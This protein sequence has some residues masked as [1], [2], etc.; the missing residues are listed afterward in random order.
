MLLCAADV[1]CAAR[2][3]GALKGNAIHPN[4]SSFFWISR[5]ALGE[6]L[7]TGPT[8]ARLLFR[9]RLWAYRRMRAGRY[10]PIVRQNA[11]HGHVDLRAVE[12]AERVAFTADDLSRAGILQQQ[13]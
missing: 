5:R 7:V 1:L 3:S 13:N 12:I 10:G 2:V 9:P 4:V 8:I 11:H 6:M